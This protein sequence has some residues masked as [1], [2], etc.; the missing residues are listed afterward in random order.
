MKKEWNGLIVG[1]DEYEPKHPQLEAPRAG[2][3]PQAL[4]NPRPD[5]TETLSVFLYKDVVGLP[6]QGPRGIGRVGSV[7]I[8]GTV[9][10][11]NIEVSVTGISTATAIGDVTVSVP[12]VALTFDSTDNT[13]DSTDNTFDEA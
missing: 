5:K 1:P 6:V 8:A 9:P 12:T 10:D 7:T 2:P 3:D 4:R 11:T 13:F